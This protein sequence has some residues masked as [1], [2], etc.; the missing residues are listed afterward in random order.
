M[1]SETKSSTE[2]PSPSEVPTRQAIVLVYDG[3]EPG[4]NAA[5]KAEALIH[6]LMDG[7]GQPKDPENWDDQ[8][9]AQYQRHYDDL[10]QRWN[11]DELLEEHDEDLAELWAHIVHLKDTRQE[12]LYPNA[13]TADEYCAADMAAEAA[14]QALPEKKGIDFKEIKERIDIV[15]HISQYTRLKKVGNKFMG[16]CPLPGHD[17]SSASFYVYPETKSFWCFGC[18]RGGDVI[19][20]ARIH[21]IMAGQL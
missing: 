5:T 2:R 3:D 14:R 4:Q 6:H 7:W 9:I 17:D 18:Q 8:L 12:N 10:L 13:T 16:K 21:G 20:F 15:D 11:T 19:D 1:N